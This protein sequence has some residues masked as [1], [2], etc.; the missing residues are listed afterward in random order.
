VTYFFNFET[1]SISL[2]RLKLQ[3]SNFY[4]QIDRQ[5]YKPENAKVGQKGSSLLN[6]TYFCNVVPLHLSN[7]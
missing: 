4:V 2:E 3:T 5:A 7:G 6:V 1:P